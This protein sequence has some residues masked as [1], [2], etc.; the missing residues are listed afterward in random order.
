MR[1]TLI[2][3]LAFSACG[4]TLV[5]PDSGE[6]Q[7]TEDAGTIIDAGVELDDA[8]VV[9]VVVDAGTPT[10]RCTV[11]PDAVTCPAL[12]TNLTAG[13][14][15]REVYWQ[16][17]VTPP[18][19][20][21]YP[22]VVMY[23]GSFFGPSTTWGTVSKDTL[24]GGYQQARLQALLLEKG[25]VVIAPSAAAGLAWQTNTGAPWDFTT[26]SKIISA[27]FDAMSRGDFGH[28]DSTRWYATGISSGGYMTSRMALS[29]AGRFR[30]LAIES[31]SWATC[32][33][34][35]CI[36]PP[37]LP[38]DH[39]PTLFL[40]GRLDLTVPLFT[41]QNYFDKLRDEGFTT[42]LVIDDD[43]S[44]EWLSVAPERVTAWFE[45]H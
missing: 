38:S 22:V 23:Q 24:F 6:P 29:Y 18:P 32:A 39:P 30:A 21:G 33:G 3:G 1:T 28:L 7:E 43:A 34:A 10:P 17:P 8:G 9:T 26:D 42:E 20:N 2:L 25:F 4:T 15:S 35:L 19:A 31:A 41:A 11:T 27:L 37:S 16:T 40:H 14:A 45:N 5:S 44:H 12:I 36:L 13:L